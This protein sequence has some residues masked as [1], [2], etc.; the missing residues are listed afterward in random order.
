ML[1]FLQIVRT[2]KVALTKV[3]YQ[4]DLQYFHTLFLKLV[5]IQINLIWLLI[6]TFE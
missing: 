6:D 1:E 4:N 5:S 2:S 3:S